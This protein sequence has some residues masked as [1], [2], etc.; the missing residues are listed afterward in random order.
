MAAARQE[1]DGS[2]SVV[3]GTGS[4]IRLAPP[5]STSII[6]DHACGGSLLRTPTLYDPTLLYAMAICLT[7]FPCT[8]DPG[9]ALD[10]AQAEWL[11]GAVPWRPACVQDGHSLRLCDT[12][13][14]GAAPLQR[15][16]PRTL[17]TESTARKGVGPA[18]LR[19]AL[20]QRPSLG[21]RLASGMRKAFTTES[22]VLMSGPP[23]KRMQAGM[24]A[25]TSSMVSRMALGLPGRFRIRALPRRPAVCLESTAVGT[26]RRD[27]ARICS[28][29]P[30]IILWHTWG[31]RV[32]VEAR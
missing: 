28:P 24:E 20:P 22:S 30:G 32:G 15:A 5:P 11:A 23:S 3:H 25:N 17:A 7:A 13:A 9:E 29:Y 12:R 4:L 16:K 10:A 21:G 19:Y 18:P 1:W 27:T 26:W 31:G 2:N 14:A 8:T 6:H